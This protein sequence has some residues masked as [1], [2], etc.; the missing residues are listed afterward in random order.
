MFRH[1]GLTTL[2]AF[3]LKDSSRNIDSLFLA[4]LPNNTRLSSVF[5]KLPVKG[6][7]R[8]VLKGALGEGA[9]VP[10]SIFGNYQKPFLKKIFQ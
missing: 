6:S 4:F 1:T 3:P 2:L 7:D 9:Q 10:C 8:G 5:N